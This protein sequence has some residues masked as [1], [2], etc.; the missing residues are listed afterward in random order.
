MIAGMNADKARE[1]A[2]AIADNV[3]DHE[4][5]CGQQIE[6]SLDADKLYRSVPTGKA[7]RGGSLANTSIMEVL[8]DV[9]TAA[10]VMDSILFSEDP[11]YD[12]QP[13]A[14]GDEAPE[15][16]ME[17]AMW[18]Q[19]AIDAMMEFNGMQTKVNDAERACALDGTV[20]AEVSWRYGVS[21][22][23]QGS[24]YEQQPYEDYADLSVV[25][26]WR[27]H[28]DP[29]AESIDDADWTLRERDMTPKAL[30]RLLDVIK[31][32]REGMDGVWLDDSIRVADFVDKGTGGKAE[33]TLEDVRQSR[34]Y[35]GDVAKGRI[36][37]W[38]YW[39]IWPVS[40]GP[41]DTEEEAMRQDF[42]TWWIIVLGGDRVAAILPNPNKHGRK[43]FLSASF[44]RQKE[45]FYGLG[46]VHLLKR[47]QREINGF[48]NLM[49]DIINLNLNCVWLSEGGTG[50][51]TQRELD[52]YPHRILNA[53][54]LGRLTPLRAPTDAL[55]PAI[56]LENM[57]KEEMR[58][59]MCATDTMQ[60][61]ASAGEHTAAEIRR[62]GSSGD[63]RAMNLAKQF[64]NAMLREW[65]RRACFLYAQFR[66]TPLMSRV[67][68]ENG[69]AMVPVS[70]DMIL[71]DPNVS[72]RL[73]FDIGGRTELRR[74]LSSAMQ[75][76]ALMMK[77]S[78]D[79][80]R[81]Y[82]IGPVFEQMVR[83]LNVDPRLVRRAAPAIPP[84]EATA[85]IEAKN[86]QIQAGGGIAEE[87][88]RPPALGIM[89]EPEAAA[90]GGM[91]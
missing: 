36:R 79:F 4:E 69:P 13:A 61:I 1:I 45:S 20:V 85:L 52:I 12:I 37:V 7:R 48:R 10:V 15:R 89:A 87:T 24:Y 88:S 66:E 17:R 35:S 64:G 72:L 43:P 67:I 5:A 41:A 29:G 30:S 9:E 53:T 50:S 21:M 16:R 86:R 59:S 63:R 18:T 31:K 2:A 47:P 3:H 8:R 71:P 90:P 91:A 77:A 80:A 39:G 19:A 70:A 58:V 74:R 51:M 46:A 56:M 28:I 81:R 78:P 62:L 33:K 27:F 57:T 32:M 73:P 42:M 40:E 75:A 60:G 38:N 11:F 55:M 23:D 6:D 83:T 22:I 54:R 26:L 82:D 68:T 84:A 14:F 34:G 25:P 76:T 44:I 49:R 65:I